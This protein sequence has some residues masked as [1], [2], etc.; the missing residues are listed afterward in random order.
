MA[1]YKL[2]GDADELARGAEESEV[3]G[4]GARPSMI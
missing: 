1:T 3:I 2:N 4:P